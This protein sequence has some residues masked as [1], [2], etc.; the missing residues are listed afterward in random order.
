MSLQSL[1]IKPPISDIDLNPG[2]FNRFYQIA[3]RFC[4][5]L[6]DSAR[7]IANNKN[8]N[9]IDKIKNILCRGIQAG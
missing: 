1:T 4:Q 2:E 5:R 7:S 8:L 6:V 3:E 9:A